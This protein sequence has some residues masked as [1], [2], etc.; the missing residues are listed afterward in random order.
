VSCQSAWMTAAE[1]LHRLPAHP[2]RCGRR[3]NPDPGCAPR[4]PRILPRPLPVPRA[5]GGPRRSLMPQ[6]LARWQR[7]AGRAPRGARRRGRRRAPTK[8]SLVTGLRAASLR[9]VPTCVTKND[10]FFSFLDG[11]VVQNKTKIPSRDQNCT[12][13]SCDLPKTGVNWVILS[14]NQLSAVSRAKCVTVLLFLLASAPASTDSSACSSCSSDA[15]QIG[16][17]VVQ[18]TPTSLSDS[19][20]TFSWGGG[21]RPKRGGGQKIRENRSRAVNPSLTCPGIILHL[22]GD[23]SGYSC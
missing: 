19:G 10:F 20:S 9:G 22:M 14:E 12:A 6:P 1:A 15:V 17:P 8:I 21:G 7:G 16:P 4:C 3:G 13:P 18:R 5:A 23:C 2:G 11:D